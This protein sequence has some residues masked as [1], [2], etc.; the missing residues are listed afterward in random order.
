VQLNETANGNGIFLYTQDAG[1]IPLSAPMSVYAV[2]PSSQSLPIQGSVALRVIGSVRGGAVRTRPGQWLVAFAGRSARLSRR[3]R[4]SRSLELVVDS[5]EDLRGVREIV[6]GYPRLL[7]NGEPAPEYGRDSGWEARFAS[8]SVPR[9]AIG[10]KKSG[11]LVMVHV[12]K[13]AGNGFGATVV[14]L[15]RIMS[16]LGCVDAL[17]LDGGS[18]SELVLGKIPLTDPSTGSERPVS[19][20]IVVGAMPARDRTLSLRLPRTMRVGQVRRVLLCRHGRVIADRAIVWTAYGSGEIT[21]RG[22]FTADAG[23]TCFVQAF[24]H[25]RAVNSVVRI[26]K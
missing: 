21:E 13:S 3:F 9:T 23:G 2:R 8:A 15:E 4:S 22:V 18:A 1:R 26:L 7:M 16:A 11:E 17:N 25:G 20:A 12:E 19:N 24:W 6:A 10:I 14:Q 5:D